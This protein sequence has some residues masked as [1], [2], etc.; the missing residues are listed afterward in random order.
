[1]VKAMGSDDEE[2]DGET[3]REDKPKEPWPFGCEVEGGGEEEEREGGKGGGEEKEGEETSEC[4]VKQK[5]NE[6]HGFFFS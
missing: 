4:S 1:M 5:D 3:R 2:E 6:R